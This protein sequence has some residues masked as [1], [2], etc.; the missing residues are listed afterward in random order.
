MMVSLEEPL[1]LGSGSPRRREILASFGL[2]FV[3]LPPDIDESRRTGE[4]PSCYLERIVREKLENVASLEPRAA[5]ILVAD[6]IVQVDDDVLGKP[7]DEVDAR[8]FLRRIAGRDHLVSTRY[9]LSTAQELAVPRVER[10]VTTIVTIRPLDDEAIARYAATGEGLDKAGAYAAQGIGA[11][12][13]A[14]I[15]GSFSGVV[16]LPVCELAQDLVA[17][18]LISGYPASRGSP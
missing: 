6:T 8:G 14:R 12:L 9:A 1:V 17:V 16:G 11:F 15:N 13:V 4:S 3:V 7:A 2:P 10:T 5:G 18:G